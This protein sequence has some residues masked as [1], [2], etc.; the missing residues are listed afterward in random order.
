MKR[1]LLSIFIPCFQGLGLLLCIPLHS[2][3]S[4]RE[5][6]H[7]AGL[8]V[9]FSQG[10]SV[11]DFN[12]DGHDDLFI[13]RRGRN[14]QLFKNLGDGTFT[15]V[16]QETGLDFVGKS[17]QS[18]WADYDADGDLD[19]YLT[20]NDEPHKLYQ[21]QG[22]E[23]FSE[24]TTQ[25]GISITG[26]PSAAIWGDVNGDNLLDLFVFNINAD[27]VFLLNNGDGTFNDYSETSG[28]AQNRLSMGATFIDFDRDGDLDLYLSHDGHAGNFMYENDG[29]G[30]YTDM[31][32]TLDIYSESEAM[33]VSVGDF[34]N[35][36]WPDLYLTNRLEN[37]LFRN[38]EGQSFTEIGAIAGVDDTGMGWGVSW[39]DYDND[40]LLDLY[41]ANDS[42][43][44]DHSNLLYKNRGDE[45]F[46]KIDQ[47]AAISS[48]KGSYSTAI[49]DLDRNGFPELLVAN[50]GNVD[51][52]ELFINQMDNDHQWVV[53]RLSRVDEKLPLIG[54][55]VRVTTDIAVHTRYLLSGTS[56]EADDS[57][58][59]LFGLGAAESISKVEVLWPTGESTEYEDIGF[60][61][62]Y[63]LNDQGAASELN[64]QVTPLQLDDDTDP[65]DR[66]VI[67]SL[68]P[69]QVFKSL[70]LYPNPS[71]GNVQLTF[72]L[73]ARQNVEID[74][75]SPIGNT[76]NALYKQA[77]PPGSHQ[78]ELPLPKGADQVLL[79][80][81]QLGQEVTIKKVIR[82]D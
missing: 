42:Y 48:E 40:G 32:I 39:L 69:D 31:S 3:D 47:D 11:V 49:A 82:K 16:A 73:T 6:A 77:L 34:N 72:D 65:G 9:T 63:I 80:K 45:T 5:V 71:S 36:G 74:L 57:K 59:L 4:F 64:Y 20:I 81:I 58:Q 25:A 18:I 27:D 50:R 12:G 66:D 43:Y 37:L 61:K 62:S 55:E 44:S 76:I 7:Q 78:I 46:E 33:G 75:L 38:N 10:V 21:N 28:I 17:H 53:F 13:T 30:N 67:T 51:R 35:D 22:D 68:E 54:A 15:D 8:G 52:A 23:T 70:N 2:Q 24:V 56:W 29:V 26:L 14:N 41:I 79:L 1:V 19:V 60:K